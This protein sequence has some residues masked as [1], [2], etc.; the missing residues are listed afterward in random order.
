MFAGD[1]SAVDQQRNT[2]KREC[3]TSIAAVLCFRMKPTSD[4][5]LAWRLVVPPGA[6][7]PT[8]RGYTQL[9]VNQHDGGNCSIDAH[10]PAE[11]PQ[12]KSFTAVSSYI[13]GTSCT[14]RLSLRATQPGHHV[15]SSFADPRMKFAWAVVMA[16]VDGI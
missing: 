10:E 2:V 12:R 8:Y 9:I 14:V 13:K 1:W 16:A 6:V 5:R 11:R 7:V 15:N 3:F 4:A